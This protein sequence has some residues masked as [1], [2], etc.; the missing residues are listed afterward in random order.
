MSAAAHHRGLI[1]KAGRKVRRTSQQ[2]FAANQ[3]SAQ[4][5]VIHLHYI[6]F[7][8]HK[9]TETQKAGVVVLLGGK[10]IRR[11]SISINFV[12]GYS[13]FWTPWPTQL[14]PMPGPG[15][16]SVSGPSGRIRFLIAH[17]SFDRVCLTTCFMLHSHFDVPL[18]VMVEG[19]GSRPG[20]H[21]LN[22]SDAMDP[23]RT[24]WRRCKRNEIDWF[25]G[26]A[27]QPNE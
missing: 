9:H 12:M 24:G 8:A 22:L 26:E 23:P 5:K 7:H 1:G 18:P 4:V 21:G 20:I 15:T 6:N 10:K 25:D 27:D 16:A 2:P 17:R 13:C 3:T 14:F 11:L 19:K